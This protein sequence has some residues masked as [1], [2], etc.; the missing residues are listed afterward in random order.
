MDRKMIYQCTCA[1]KKNLDY[2]LFLEFRMI[3]L[4]KGGGALTLN[5]IKYS[6]ILYLF[7]SLQLYCRFMFQGYHPVRSYDLRRNH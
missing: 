6:Y 1:T 2:L 3:T 4:V 5:W 7:L